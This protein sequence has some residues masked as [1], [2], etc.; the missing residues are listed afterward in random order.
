MFESAFSELE[1]EYPAR[2]D[3]ATCECVKVRGR[4]VVLITAPTS[5]GRLG[6]LPVTA[7]SLGVIPEQIGF[8]RL[9]P[10]GRLPDHAATGR[11]VITSAGIVVTLPEGTLGA[12]RT[13]AGDLSELEDQTEVLILCGGPHSGRSPLERVKLAASEKLAIGISAEVTDLRPTTERHPDVGLFTARG[14][15]GLEWPEPGTRVVID[16]NFL[17]SLD[18]CLSTETLS[19]ETRSLW[20]HMRDAM[21]WLACCDTIPGYALAEC[22][23][24]EGGAKRATALQAALESF[25]AHALVPADRDALK[26]TYESYVPSAEDDL[27]DSEGEVSPLVVLNYVA[28]LHAYRLWKGQ[29]SKFVPRERMDA[30]FEWLDVLN[31]DAVGIPAHC[32]VLVRALLLSDR[33]D[34][35]DA[36]ARQAERLLKFGQ[37]TSRQQTSRQQTSRE[38]LLGAAWDLT[39]LGLKDILYAREVP[40][41]G[42]SELVFLTADKPLQSLSLNTDLVAVIETSAGPIGAVGYWAPISTRFSEKQIEAIE[43]REQQVNLDQHRRAAS[44]GYDVAKLYTLVKALEQD[45]SLE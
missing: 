29:Q 44:H 6:T 37:Q 10:S 7:R 8:G 42:A 16:Q 24:W 26:A 27:A 5:T 34:S 31:D 14:G 17:V 11:V 28:V 3:W 45:L 35:R 2:F 41:A 36:P 13:P 30:W 38:K 9:S 20:A 33:G 4:F 43:A 23:S 22:A 40:S 1:T 32:R 25:E 21:A 19:E 39:Y 18:K 15:N 12:F